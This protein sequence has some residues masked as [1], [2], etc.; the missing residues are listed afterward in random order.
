MNNE[1]NKNVILLQECVLTEEL[2]EN[3]IDKEWGSTTLHSLGNAHSKGDAI[4][5]IFFFK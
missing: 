4:L 5:V 2:K 1:I 3:I